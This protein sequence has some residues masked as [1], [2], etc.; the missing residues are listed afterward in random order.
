[1]HLNNIYAEYSELYYESVTTDSNGRFVFTKVPAGD[2]FSLEVYDYDSSSLAGNAGAEDVIFSVPANSNF[3][4]GDYNLLETDLVLL[5]PKRDSQLRDMPSSL[6]WEAYPGAAYYHV[7]LKQM[8]GT[9]TDLELDTNDT[10]VDLELPLMACTYGWDVTAYSSAG[11]P[12]ARSD[13]A[14]ED[15]LK[16]FTQ[17]Y[18]GI[19]SIQNDLLPWCEIVLI[20]PP[21]SAKL[22][23]GTV[24]L[25]WEHHPLAATYRVSI[26]RLR[27]LSQGGPSIDPDFFIGEYIVL[28]DSNLE[29]PSLP[30]FGSGSY[31]WVVKAFTEEGWNIAGSR[32]GYFW[33]P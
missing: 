6:D 24:E 29:G 14:Y 20:S 7:E 11:T 12:L 23:G 19:F 17:K 25:I 28:E 33:I 1:M 10:H 31:Y 21:Y 8:F 3:N 15:Q 16:S 18:D 27:S 9:V 4:F 5:S 2:G 13:S 30:S 26:K 32:E 22:T